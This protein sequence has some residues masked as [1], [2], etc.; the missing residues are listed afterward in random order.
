MAGAPL[1]P[2]SAHPIV[3]VWSQ[4]WPTVLTMTSFTVMQFSDKLM[5]GQVGYVELA[6]QGNGGIWAFTPIATIIG[7]LTVVNTFVSQNLGAGKPER[8]P[9]Y[10][11]NGLWLAIACWLV[12]LL[13]FSFAIPMLFEWTVQFQKVDD[14]ARL[15]ALQTQYAQILLWGAAITLAGRAMHN[16]FFGLHRPRVITISAIVGNLANVLANY[17]LIFG[18]DGIPAYGLPGIPG[19]P[20]LGL[21][22][23]AIGTLI[24][25]A[26]EVSIPMAIFLGP[27]MN[28]ELKTR[29]AWRPDQSA[30]RDLLR[31]GWP[32]AMQYG[33]EIICWSIFMTTLVGYFGEQH[34]SAGWI[35][36]Q[37]MHL[38]FMPAVGFSTAVNSIVG[39]YIGAGQPDIAHARARLGMTMA[40]V[41]MTLCAVFFVAFRHS[42]IALFIG[43]D[44]EP[45]VREEII[46]IG[47]RLL[48][49]AAVFQVF[50]AVGIVYTG[51]LRGAGDT[52]VPGILTAVF[53]WV[54]IVGGGLAM[55]RWF[56]ELESVGPWIGASAFIIVFG[57]TMA[58]RFE[59]GRWRSIELVNKDG[60]AAAG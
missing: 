22:G 6:A 2:G 18:E 30:I 26:V 51:A 35:A 29:A 13:P 39:R 9:A 8:G 47:G 33:N 14:P 38:S 53:S 48:I 19:V 50:D 36:L 52:I 15:V 58:W 44:V 7:F 31:V 56:S 20:A 54:F 41:Y 17:V 21:A 60:D 40:L 4:A 16:Y 23:A 5:V 25:T 24:G 10:A 45:A 59:R 57:I 12:F 32:A 37:Y 11:W 43:G 49:C 1:S 3:E 28:R 46:A 55:I 34:M 42:L 27:A